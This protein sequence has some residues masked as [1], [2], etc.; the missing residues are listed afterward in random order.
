MQQ[1]CESV[2]AIIKEKL[3]LLSGKKAIKEIRT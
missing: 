2:M 1:E 3:M